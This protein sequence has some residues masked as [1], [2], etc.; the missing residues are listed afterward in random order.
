VWF[1]GIIL[2][3]YFFGRCI[4][5]EISIRLREAMQGGKDLSQKYKRKCHHDVD[6][7]TVRNAVKAK[8]NRGQLLSIKDTDYEETQDH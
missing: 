1:I 5:S 4:L 3:R 2:S 6:G 7:W 8:K